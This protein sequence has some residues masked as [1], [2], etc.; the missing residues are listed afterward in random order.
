MSL[1]NAN[2]KTKRDYTL[3]EDVIIVTKRNESMT[4]SDI[5]EYLTEL[6][7]ER[8]DHSV[9]YRISRKLMKV[10]RL[11]ELYKVDSETVKRVM[12]EADELMNPV[13]VTEEES[14][15]EIEEK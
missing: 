11:E 3:V 6:G 7:F 4:V 12:K 5:A 14:T 1:I 9:Q 2:V 8:S 15:T 13:E 10:D